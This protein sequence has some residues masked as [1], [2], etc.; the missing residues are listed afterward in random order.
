MALILP[1]RDTNPKNT[2]DA[3]NLA[4]SLGIPHLKIDIS[5]IIKELGAYDLLSHDEASDRERVEQIAKTIQVVSEKELPSTE[6]F[7]PTIVV[8][9][10]LSAKDQSFI[11]FGT[12]NTI[13][14][15]CCRETD[16]MESQFF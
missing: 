13:K 7:S 11:A 3:M 8:G 1:E 15:S 14:L 6:H 10:S 4:K 12:A 2:E 5:P 16:R 9:S